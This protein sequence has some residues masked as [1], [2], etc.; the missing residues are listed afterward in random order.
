MNRKPSRFYIIGQKFFYGFLSRISNLQFNPNFGNFSMISRRVLDS[1]LSLNGSIGFYPAA[2]KWLGFPSSTVD[3]QVRMRPPESNSKYTFT[4][5][6][7]LALQVIIS[8]SERPLRLIVLVGAF[9]AITGIIL[10]L[11]VF[12]AYFNGKLT[13]PGWPS[14][15]VATVLFSG[16]QFLS[17]GSLGLYI[18]EINKVTKN[19]PLYVVEKEIAK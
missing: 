14:L 8:H 3:Y 7:R 15:F 18:A 11:I 6:V 10:A 13:Q 2:I 19:R 4:S 17:L 9:F 16:F 5:R 1:Y 12:W